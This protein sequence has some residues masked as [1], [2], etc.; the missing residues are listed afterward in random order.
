MPE[1]DF[2]SL[3]ILSHRLPIR[4]KKSKAVRSAL[5]L[6]ILFNSASILD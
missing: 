2:R 6:F 4:T 1:L 5:L 3:I